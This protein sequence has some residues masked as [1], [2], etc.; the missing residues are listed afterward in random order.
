[1]TYKEISGQYRICAS[2]TKGSAGFQLKIP[3][4]W[5]QTKQKR[6]NNR[7]KDK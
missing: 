3:V 2:N 6:K 5:M 4:N 1:M 7:S